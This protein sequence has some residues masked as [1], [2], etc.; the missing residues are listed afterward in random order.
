MVTA[1]SKLK[2]NRQET[3]TTMNITRNASLTRPTMMT[4][5]TLCTGAV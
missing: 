4:A 2:I 1:S 5:V 3:M